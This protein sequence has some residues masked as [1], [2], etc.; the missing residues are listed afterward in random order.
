[1]N[2]NVKNMLFVFGGYWVI[3]ELVEYNE[4]WDMY[5]RSR[6]YCDSVQKPLLRVGIR[7]GPF[8]PPNGDVTIDISDEILDVPGG[9]VGDERDMPFADKE[10]G[11]CF[12]EH[13]I[14]H[15]DD[16]TTI[17]AAISECIRVADY[18]VIIA[19]GPY[20]YGGLFHP[21]HKVRL[22]FEDDHI[23]V[24]AR[25]YIKNWTNLSFPGI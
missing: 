18:A 19:P 2:K 20:T 13:T 12:N 1:M 14:E 7:R 8:E 24:R 3:T 25:P 23:I 11:V 22:W 21:D 15:I 17:G 6:E 16:P 5:N 10:F 4:R 9:I